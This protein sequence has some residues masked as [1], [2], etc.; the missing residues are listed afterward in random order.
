MVRDADAVIALNAIEE[1]AYN[2][3][4]AKNVH[5]IPNGVDCGEFRPQGHPPLPAT[6]TVPENYLFFAGA[7]Q[8]QKGIF[9]LLDSLCRIGEKG[10]R[11]HVLVAG[12]GPELARAQSLVRDRRL[13]VSFAGRIDR[14]YMPRLMADA[15]LFVLPS[16][17]ETSAT[18]YLEAMASG[19]P[20]VGTASG[21]TPEIIIDGENGFLI[22]VGDAGML[23]KV[24]ENHYAPEADKAVHA[25]M[26]R[27]ARQ[28]AQDHFDW[29]ILTPRLLQAYLP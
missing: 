18:V 4:G 16:E 9:T 12:D 19:T 7:V 14:Q 20:C 13:N 28:R 15:E 29:S 25:S 6:L 2:A 22:P 3:L 23:A 5:R 8:T 21:G 11:P 24:I 27:N 1:K 17:Y 10:L 26:K